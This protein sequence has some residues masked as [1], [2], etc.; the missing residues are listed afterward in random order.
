MKIMNE[1]LHLRQEIFWG[2]ALLIVSPLSTKLS[3]FGPEDE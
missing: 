2:A 1:R 3:S